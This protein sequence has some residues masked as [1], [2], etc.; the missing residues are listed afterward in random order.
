MLASI[1]V[2][3]ILG[4]GG[5]IYGGVRGW[6]PF[7]P[8]E[9]DS[10]LELVDASFMES[11]ETTKLDIKVRNVSDEVA[12]LKAADF[13]VEKIWKLQH[14]G[15][16]YAVPVSKNYNVVLKP[17]GIPYTQT[18]EISQALKPNTVDRFTFTLGLDD[19]AEPLTWY[20][21]LMNV[22]FVYDEEDRSMSTGNLLFVKQGAYDIQAV[23]TLR[24]RTQKVLK[25]DK[26]IVEE[27]KETEGIKSAQL[28][29]LLREIS[30][31][32]IEN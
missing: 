21:P 25:A 14:P 26:P 29:E 13:N 20:V 24:D 11:N 27:I 1:A 19:T 28:E 18:K 16:P 2:A 12:F 15:L 8:S 3:V 7:I 5:L 32:E 4:V 23:T 10:K 22:D 9:G 17:S 6:L 30:K 31:A